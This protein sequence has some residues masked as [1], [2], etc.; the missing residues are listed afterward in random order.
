MTHYDT[1]RYAPLFATGAVLISAAVMAVTVVLP[2]KTSPAPASASHIEVSIE[3]ARIEVV[4]VRT[5][6]AQ[7]NAHVNEAARP[8]S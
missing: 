6:R 5:A 3:P 7:T 8:V 4:G 2:A 1:K